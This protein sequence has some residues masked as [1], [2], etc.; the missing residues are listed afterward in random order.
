[1]LSGSSTILSL[2]STALSEYAEHENNIREIM[3]DVREREDDFKEM[4]MLR[5]I[6]GIKMDAAEKRVSKLEPVHKNFEQQSEILAG[7]RKEVEEMDSQISTEEA[8]LG[9]FKRQAARNWME[10]K[11]GGLLDCTR[12]GTVRALARNLVVT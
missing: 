12:K 9:D 6:L 3:K 8:E 1:V 5:R 11:L 4:K 2:F 7:L 10:L